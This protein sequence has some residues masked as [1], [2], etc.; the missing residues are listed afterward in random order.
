MLVHQSD[1]F[2]AKISHLVADYVVY[3]E[4]NLDSKNIIITKYL[5]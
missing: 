4:G 1:D 2:C 5:W 3:Y